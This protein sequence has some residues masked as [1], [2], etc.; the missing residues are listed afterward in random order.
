[1]ADKSWYGAPMR[2]ARVQMADGR[3]ARVEVPA[4]TSPE[5]ISAYAESMARQ[6]AP[7]PAAAP[8]KQKPESFW[9]GVLEEVGRG[10]NNAFGY[11][12]KMPV[13]G[14]PLRLAGNLAAPFTGNTSLAKA[15]RALFENKVGQTGYKGSTAGKIVGT[16]AATLPTGMAPGGV[17]AQGAL[18]GAL[19]TNDPN[20]RGLVTDALTGAAGGY[21]GDKAA[22]LARNVISPTVAPVIQR[23]KDRG[24]P[25]TVGQIAGAN[26][27]AIGNAVRGFENKLTSVPGVGDMISS[28][29]RRGKDAFQRA[30]FDEGLAPIGAKVPRVA[31]EGIE[32]AKDEVGKA[33]SRAFND[34][35]ITPDR[36][37]ADEF[38]QAGQL[39]KTDGPF[40]DDFERIMMDEV[41]PV[42]T[43]QPGELHGQNI[44]DA[45]RI[46]KGYGRQ[47]G[48][49][50]TKGAGGIPQPSARPVGMAF[51]DLA[52]SVEGL[53]ARQAPDLMPAYD[54]A[55]SAYRNVG[56]LRDAV[57]AA[58]NTGGEFTAAQLAQAARAN[59]K[60]FGGT[61]GTTKQPFFDLTRDAQEVLPSTIPDSGSAGRGFV[62][63]MMGG[64]GGVP[65]VAASG[66]ASLP[67]TKTG[68]ELAEWLLTGRQGRLS[69]AAAR[70][71]DY[72]RPGLIGA[73]GAG[74]AAI[75]GPTLAQL[76]GS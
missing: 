4:D 71:I 58:K 28:A 67:Y 69:K 27:G 44:Q 52:G 65:A 2:V 64:V 70:G 29:Q 61:Q 35:R 9:Q 31:E 32:A 24:I 62:G 76:L 73:G 68:Q 55:N 5:Q 46:L 13:V 16:V 40:R 12:E 59:A 41:R 36:E 38:F 49:L 75:G 42:L 21:L 34:V 45:L 57:S 72:L 22:K 25:L 30:A 1:M 15:A 51:N 56:V 53:A 54:A 10:A 18:G 19:A 3:V 33:Y 60:K 43:D 37:F 8:A 7:K 66:V 14:D 6:Q 50:A 17:L 11:V 26:G 23:L 47:Y 20:G 39:G 63:L 74:A 48:D